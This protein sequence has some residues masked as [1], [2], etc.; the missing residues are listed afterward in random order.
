M[1]PIPQVAASQP[2][3]AD[4]ASLLARY[5]SL[6]RAELEA[7]VLGVQDLEPFY[8]MFAYHLGWVD[9]DFQPETGRAGKSLRPSLCL[10][11]A[12]ALGAAAEECALLAAGIELL[13]N[14][15]LIHDDIEDRSLTRRG[16]EAVWTVWGEAQAINAGDGMFS[17]AHLAWL[18][19]PIAETDPRAF[20]AI[21]RLLERTVLT[22]C[23]GQFQDMRAERSLDL[24]IEAYLDMIGRK[25]A[26]LIGASTWVGARA[27]TADE[28]VLTAAH[29]FGRQIGLAFQ[30]RDDVLGIWGDEQETGKSVSS[31]IATRKMTLPVIIALQEGN[32]AQRAALRARYGSP[33]GDQEDEVRIR[34]W[35]EAANAHDR[36]VAR[37][38]VHWQAAMQA[39]ATLPLDPLWR[40][41]LH[42]FARAVMARRA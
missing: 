18:H 31:D 7:L 41:R 42:E 38:H 36:A 19:A 8:G 27:A 23:E 20:I 37:E 30:I 25:T 13:H 29:D 34:E 11:M 15:S 28:R 39:L 17:L 5:A 10:L 4:L 32:P 2:G 40:S 35:L 33:P 12:E 21:V 6:V 24:S 16:R 9:R 1:L 26:A 22:L 3:D 14:F